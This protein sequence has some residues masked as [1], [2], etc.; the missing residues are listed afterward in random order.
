MTVKSFTAILI[1]FFVST[2]LFAQSFDELNEKFIVYY[3]SGDY[4]KAIEYGEKALHQ[5]EIKFGKNDT[6]YIKILNKLGESYTENSQYDKAEI[7]LQE[8]LKITKELF[9]ENHPDYA[10]SLNNLGYLYTVI[11][12]YEKAEPLYLEAMKIDKEV[13]GE[14][15]PDY[16]IDLNNLATLYDMTG[17]YEKSESLYLEALKIRKEILGEKHPD[18]AISLCNL[19]ILYDNLGQYKK[20]EELFLEAIEIQKEI[21]GVNHQDYAQTVNNLACLKLKTGDYKNAETFFLEVIDILK[22][23]LGKQNNYYAISLNNLAN[24]YERMRDYEKSERLYKEAIELFKEIFGEKHP[25]YASALSNLAG[26]YNKTGEYEKAESLYLKALDIRKEMLGEKHPDYTNSL[27]NLATL[28]VK[29][30]KYDYADTLFKKANENYLYQ[31]RNNFTFLSEK[32]KIDYLNTINSGLDNFYSFAEKRKKDV[33]SIVGD[34]LLLRIASKGVVLNSTVHMY[35]KI[36]ESNDPDLLN[37]Y[38]ELV[39]LKSSLINAQTLTAEERN[40]RG[41]NIAELESKSEAVEKQL[42][43]FADMGINENIGYEDVKNSLKENEAA[44]EFVDYKSSVADE[45]DTIVYCAVII[46]KDLANPELIRLCS[47]DDLKNLLDVP[48]ENRNSYVRNENKCSR[49]YNLTFKPLMEILKGTDKIFISPSGIL[50]K[51]SFEILKTDENEILS[52]KFKIRYAGNLKDIVALND[53]IE[54]RSK[55]LTAAV[56]GGLNYDADSTELVRNSIKYRGI[57][58]EDFKYDNRTVISGLY[59]YRKWEY[60]EGTLKEAD[61]ISLMLEKNGYKVNK[62]TG[63]EGNEE[64]FK[65]LNGNNSPVI[66]HISTHG[67]FNPETGEDSKNENDLPVPREIFRRSNN[68]LL[69]SGLIFAGA[70]RVW[71]GGREIEGVENGILTAYEVSNMDLRNT[72]LVVL[73]ACET[74]LGDIKGGEGV[75]GLQRAFKVAGAK[76]I[77]MSLWKVP[78]EATMELMTLFYK[79]LLEE[80]M[81]REEAFDEAKNQIRKKYN[82]PYFWA[83]FIMN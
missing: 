81:Q 16:V 54:L 46:K 66:L 13:L 65:S 18:F 4:K 23:I 67:F 42:S 62:Y 73:S 11:G 17:D 68:P 70:N 74:G 69:R 61:S 27:L 76:N 31:L 57:L 41:L 51:V 79:N 24:T 12:D 52:D 3:N 71:T 56:Y 55:I 30:G 78:D 37:K 35:K 77:I 44:V 39:S 9:G 53:N 6:A 15:H 14:K 60:L 21:P 28:Y 32:Q 29:A 22:N 7:L 58:N 36:K 5:A 2:C 48:A 20:A 82:E 75:F 33:P 72:E 10:V 63:F 47:L 1:F 43:K 38:N 26:L 80:K 45:E 83:G 34:M 40:K 49:L 64:S 19:G 25:D 8:S 50:N 59:E